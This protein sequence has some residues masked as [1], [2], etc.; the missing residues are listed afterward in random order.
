[1]KIRPEMLIGWLG[2]VVNILCLIVFEATGLADDNIAG[3]FVYNLI[4]CIV[5]LVGLGLNFPLLLLLTLFWWVVPLSIW[6]IYVSFNLHSVLSRD[7]DSDYYFY[8]R[9]EVYSYFWSALF[10]LVLSAIYDYLVLKIYLRLRNS[11]QT[12]GQIIALHPPP[13]YT[14]I[15][16]GI[17]DKI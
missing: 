4:G 5:W 9:R 13:L 15:Y 6:A 17:T 10:I 11:R 14:G 2:V 12:N 7:Y 16:A 8:D 3:S 1:M